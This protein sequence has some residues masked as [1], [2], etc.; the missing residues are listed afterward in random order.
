MRSLKIL[1]D[2]HY[3][4]SYYKTTKTEGKNIVASLIFSIH[5]Y[6]VVTFFIILKKN[7]LPLNQ[8]YFYHFIRCISHYKFVWRYSV[9]SIYLWIIKEPKYSWDKKKKTNTVGQR[10]CCLFF[11][12]YSKFTYITLRTKKLSHWNRGINIFFSWFVL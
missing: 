3:K 1:W 8:G 12:E 6:I 11:L 4:H 10:C 9:Y 5:H 2:Q 7:C